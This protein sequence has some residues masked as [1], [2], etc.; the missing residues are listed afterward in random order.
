MVPVG[1]TRSTQI[2]FLE[3]E[4]E[5]HWGILNHLRGA[6]PWVRHGVGPPPRLGALLGVARPPNPKEGRRTGTHIFPPGPGA[7][8]SC[9]VGAGAWRGSARSARPHPAPGAP[10]PPRRGR[11]QHPGSPAGHTLGPAARP[12]LYLRLRRRPRVARA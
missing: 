10:Q 6:G 9:G 12:C 7:K 8:G 2:H 3:T 4:S 1:Y 5:R 11:S